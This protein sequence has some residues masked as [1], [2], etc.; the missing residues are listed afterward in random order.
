MN[1]GWTHIRCPRCGRHAYNPVK[2]YCAACGWGQIKEDQAL[3]MAE[4]EGQ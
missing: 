4:Q 2:G 3:L 1:N